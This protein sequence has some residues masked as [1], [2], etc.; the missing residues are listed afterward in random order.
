MA[1]VNGWYSAIGWNQPGIASTGTKALEMSGRKISGMALLLA[2]SAFG[3]TRPM[4]TAIQV[5]ARAKSTSSPNAASHSSTVASVERKPMATPTAPTRTT[6]MTD[7]RTLP[8]TCPTSTDPRWIAMVR[9]RAMMPSLMSLA[10]ETAV[11]I[12]V[13]PMVISSRPGT[14]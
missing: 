13:L 6:L 8:T 4:P 10:T 7:C 5:S 3:L 1:G 9:K 12:V 11:P 2:A 14:R